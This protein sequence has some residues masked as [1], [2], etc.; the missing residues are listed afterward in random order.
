MPFQVD[1]T[2]GYAKCDGLLKGCDAR[3]T[4]A[5][6]ALASPYN[7]YTQLGWPPTPIANPGEDAIRAALTPKDS[8]YL[9]Y[10]SSKSGEILFSK[11]LDEHNT[12][13]AKYL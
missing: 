6:T 3:I 13:R 10:L 11:T 5:D 12:K 4:K 9:Y 1:A 8:P 7:T 2:L